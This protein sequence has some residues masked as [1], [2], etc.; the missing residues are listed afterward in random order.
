M[1][2]IVRM[3][4]VYRPF[5]SLRYPQWIPLAY[6]FAFGFLMLLNEISFAVFHFFHVNSFVKNAIV[7]TVDFCFTLNIA[8]F[9][10]GIFA[11]FATIFKIVVNRRPGKDAQ[12]QHIR[13]CWII[14][15]MNIPYIFSIVNYALCKTHF[16]KHGYFFLVY[17]AI[18]CFTS[19]FNPVVIVL[20]NTEIRRFMKSLIIRKKM[21]AD[22]GSLNSFSKC[23]TL[24]LQMRCFDDNIRM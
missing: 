12:L 2:A 17:V 14:F 10:F 20:L 13:S 22:Q 16:E 19:M 15:L 4:S 7:F 8:H 11:S 3:I 21:T 9:C 24:S 18:P 6:V 23:K 1:L 5:L